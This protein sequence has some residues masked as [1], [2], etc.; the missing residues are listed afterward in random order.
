MAAATAVLHVQDRAVRRSAKYVIR[1]D[2]TYTM[3]FYSGIIDFQK[4]AV[5]NIPGQGSIGLN[6]FFG[7]Q[8]LTI[9]Y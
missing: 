2:A 5:I 4:W 9:Y 8:V 6:T 7:S 3:A 1:T